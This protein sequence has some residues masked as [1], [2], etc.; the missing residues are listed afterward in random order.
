MNNISKAII[1]STFEKWLTH[2]AKK[3]DPLEGIDL[4]EE[5]K[6]IMEKKSNLSANLRKLVVYR[7]EKENVTKGEG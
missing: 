3:D 7:Y 4:K 5:Y 2:Y 6:L 1:Y